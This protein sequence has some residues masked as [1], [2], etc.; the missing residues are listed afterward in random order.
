MKEKRY[1]Y[2]VLMGKIEGQRTLGRS[3]HNRRY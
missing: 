3:T 2:R 1:S